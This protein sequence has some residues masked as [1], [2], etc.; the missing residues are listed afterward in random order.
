M[1]R[2]VVQYKGY[3][4]ALHGQLAVPFDEPFSKKLT[5]HPGTI[6][7]LPFNWYSF[8]TASKCSWCFGFTNNHHFLLICASH[9]STD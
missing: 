2:C 8:F 1:A 5:G 9:I 6:V 7:P 4:A 3:L